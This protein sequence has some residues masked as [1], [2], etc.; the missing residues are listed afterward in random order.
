MMRPLEAG[1]GDPSDEDRSVASGRTMSDITAGAGKPASPF[2]TVIGAPAGSI[3]KS[4]RNG[5]AGGRPGDPT[6]GQKV[7]G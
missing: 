2:M 5:G 1:A 6:E 7:C 4:N 3:W